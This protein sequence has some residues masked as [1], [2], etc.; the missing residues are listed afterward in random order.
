MIKECQG[1]GLPAAELSRHVEDSR[2][3]RPLPVET[4]DDF[5]RKATEIGRQIGPVEESRRL[6]IVLVGP[7]LSHLIQVD[8]EL[9]SIER[10]TLPEILSRD[11]NL[12]PRFHLRHRTGPP[13]VLEENLLRP[14]SITA[15]GPSS[16]PALHR[17]NASPRRASDKER[18]APV[19]GSR[20]GHHDPPHPR[21]GIA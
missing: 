19:L 8:C 15:L 11:R 21:P 12:V 2:G 13:R 14:Y 5:A 6:L 10:L 4:P 3:L 16:G 1:V 9:R 17:P 20:I 18:R 7:T